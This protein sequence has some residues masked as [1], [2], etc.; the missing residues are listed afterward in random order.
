MKRPAVLEPALAVQPRI[1]G[2]D[3][4][5]AEVA[6]QQIATEFSEPGWSEREP[7]RRVE[8]FLRGDAPEEVAGHVERVHV[9]VPFSRNIILFIGVL[10]PPLP[11]AARNLRQELSETS[12][13]G[14]RET[15]AVSSLETSV[16]ERC[17]AARS[18]K[19]GPRKTPTHRDVFG[20]AKFCNFFITSKRVIRLACP[21]HPGSQLS[22][23]STVP[24]N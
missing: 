11:R 5:V 15:K 3:A 8:R 1:V 9:T 24:P 2:M 6:D 23:S 12:L 14:E 10:Q 4:T 22:Y 18:S 7:P 20:D 16:V 17:H 19:A 21:V 13:C